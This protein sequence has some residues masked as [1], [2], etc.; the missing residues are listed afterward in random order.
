MK[1]TPY[2]LLGKCKKI[3]E[4]LKL[5]FHNLEFWDSSILRAK[6]INFEIENNFIKI[7]VSLKKNTKDYMQFK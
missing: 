3:K 4:L 2:Q 7:M 6:W 5:N 1:I